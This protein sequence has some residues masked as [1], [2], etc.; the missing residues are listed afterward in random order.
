[1]SSW[2]E[3]LEKLVS[4]NLKVDLSNFVNFHLTV[5][6]KTDLPYIY[7]A[8]K[9][10]VEINLNKIPAES[11]SELPVIV[12]EYVEE[13]NR[14]LEK[15]SSELLNKLYEYTTQNPDGAILDFFRLIIPTQDYEALEAALYLRRIFRSHGDV[16]KLKT[17]IK[18]RFGD[19]GTNITN[20]STAGYFETFLIPLYN[21]STKEQFKE[22]YEIIVEKSILAV[23]VHG[24]MDEYEITS[25]IQN[26]LEIS[27]KY[28]I[29]FIHIHGIGSQNIR[30]IKDYLHA[31]L[32]KVD[33]LEKRIFEKE[34]I[35]ILELIRK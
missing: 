15:E 12:K 29:K 28:G 10:I 30:K 17:D 3:K 18:K 11:R 32:E 16:R 31:Y 33:F 1:M 26:K 14:L 8:E 27:K 9:K 34:N 7:N 4:I 35:I 24:E 23:F 25:Q 6:Q 13:G 19:R 21:N 2:F 22:L 20:L 5:N